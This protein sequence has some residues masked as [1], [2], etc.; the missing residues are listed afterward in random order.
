MN[1]Y[2]YYEYIKEHEKKFEEDK[3]FE[4]KLDSIIIGLKKN[5]HNELLAFYKWVTIKKNI[6]QREKGIEIDFDAISS[7]KEVEALVND[8]KYEGD[9]SDKLENLLKNSQYIKLF[10]S[11]DSIVNKLW[12]K[13]IRENKKISLSNLKEKITD[14]VRT[15]IVVSNSF[16]AEYFA[17]QLSIR[18][19]EHEGTIRRDYGVSLKKIEFE[20]ELKMEKGYFAYH[21]LFEFESGFI[22]ELQIFSNLMKEWRKLSHIIYEELRVKDEK[23]ENSIGSIETRMT[24]LGHL[25]HIAECEINDLKKQVNK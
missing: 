15:E 21:L 16:D 25:L 9:V 23:E 22:L 11:K 5:Y 7:L 6:I 24:S 1:K 3:E 10:K 20:P 17:R 12:R 2:N 8:R 13:N 18:N 19:D 4:E 14:L